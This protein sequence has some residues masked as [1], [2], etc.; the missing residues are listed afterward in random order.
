MLILVFLVSNIACTHVSVFV[1]CVSKC[2]AQHRRFVVV[3]FVKHYTL[4]NFVE[5]VKFI[6]TLSLWVSRFN[7][8]V[9]PGFEIFSESALEIHCF[10]LRY[11][12]AVTHADK[13][14]LSV[15]S[16]TNKSLSFQYITSVSKNIPHV[17]N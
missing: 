1:K 14:P 12:V 16:A 3:V 5:S 6:S 9:G 17:C 13:R 4:E 10:A 7:L 2:N 15:V 8:S 11:S